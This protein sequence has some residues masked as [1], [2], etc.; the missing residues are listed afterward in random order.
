[1]GIVSHMSLNLSGGS[2]YEHWLVV[3]ANG[4]IKYHHEND[5]H[6]VFRHG[7]QATDVEWTLDQVRARFPD[8]AAV[9]EAF[10]ASEKRR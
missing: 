1:M 3:D 9:I 6:A 8:K 2:Q 7:L 10:F 4:S 5:G